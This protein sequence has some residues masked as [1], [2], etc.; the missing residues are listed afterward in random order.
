MS[1]S[2]RIFLLL[3]CLSAL[4]SRLAVAESE[5]V[6][7]SSPAVVMHG[8]PAQPGSV[9]SAPEEHHFPIQSKRWSDGC[10]GLNF[11]WICVGEV[12]P[13]DPEITRR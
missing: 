12:V 3:A 9:P 7:G 13:R 2:R 1:P 11:G 5:V 6:L 8:A 4:V 10:K